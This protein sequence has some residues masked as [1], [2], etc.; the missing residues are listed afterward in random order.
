MKFNLTLQD[1]AVLKGIAICAMLLH[2]LFYENPEY[3]HIIW[4]FALLGKVCV[5]LFLF[6]SGFGLTVQ[7]SKSTIHGLNINSGGHVLRFLLKRFLKFYLNYWVI[8]LIFVPIGVLFFNRPLVVPYGEHAN[9]FLALLKDVFGLQR[10]YSY[11]ITWWFNQLIITLWLLFPL[12]YLLIRNKYASWILLP[13]SMIFCPEKG[14]A[15]I[16][17]IYIAMYRE[18]VNHVIQKI[19]FS[20]SLFLIALILV[21]LCVNRE[22]MCVAW[23]SG[24]FA[25]PYIAMMLSIFVAVFTTRTSCKLPLFIFLGRHSMNMYMVHTFIFAYFFH[26]FIYGFKYPIFIFVALLLSSLAV[27]IVLEYGKRR[28]GLYSL[29]N[30][31]SSKLSA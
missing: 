3:G 5:A 27:S 19:G 18:N 22:K 20:C 30:Y 8:F 24:T 13:I 10:F 26:D 28:L 9:I 4:H 21:V 1:T 17:G 14:L 31:I 6:L 11:N 7:F 23:L 25:D 29:L 2:H 16:L 15:F 12:F